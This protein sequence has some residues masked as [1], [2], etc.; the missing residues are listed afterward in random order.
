VVVG[1]IEEPGR[2]VPGYGDVK[3]RQRVLGGFRR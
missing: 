1:V 3:I 2:F